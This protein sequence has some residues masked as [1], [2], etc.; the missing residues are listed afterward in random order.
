[1][2]MCGRLVRNIAAGIQTRI[3]AF[4][5]EKRVWRCKHL[6]TPVKVSDRQERI[7]GWEQEK[8]TQAT[9]L[10]VGAGGI[11]G[12]MCEGA[13]QK[14]LG[15]VHVADPD[16]VTP[17]NLNRQKF[18]LK[19]LYHNK[20]KALCRNLS[21]RG[22][23]GTTLIAHPCLFQDLNLDEINPTFVVCGVDNQ[24]PSTR[25]D[26]CRACHLRRIPLITIGVSTDAGAGYVLVQEPEAACWACVFKPELDAQQDKG[27]ERCPGEPACVDIL[28][29]LAGP[30][31]YAIDSL[32]IAV[33]KLISR[34]LV[35]TRN[36]L[37]S[38]CKGNV[39]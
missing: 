33:I 16:V 31:L 25:L 2:R 3:D 32:L 12:E 28:K 4:L 37:G 27:K 17:S 35:Y 6:V 13:V 23:L 26:I 39:C 29:A 11:D 10:L 30:G 1:M 7:P 36:C 38:S 21:K 8:E 34:V 20:A 18:V 22:F 19:D 15:I 5:L 24:I 14:G 9:G